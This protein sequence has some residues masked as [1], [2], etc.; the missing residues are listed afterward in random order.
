MIRWRMG[1]SGHPSEEGLRVISLETQIWRKL[2]L[3]KRQRHFE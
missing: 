3:K 2:L 1:K